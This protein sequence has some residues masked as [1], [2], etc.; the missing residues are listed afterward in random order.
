MAATQRPST[1]LRLAPPCRP[2]ADTGRTESTRNE[3]VDQQ[4][5]GLEQQAD[6]NHDNGE[7]VRQMRESRSSGTVRG[8]SET[9]GVRALS[10]KRKTG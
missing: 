10:T 2:T 9:E 3:S 7:L 6:G 1:S 8:A 5:R 4:L